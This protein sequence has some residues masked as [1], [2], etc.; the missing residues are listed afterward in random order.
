MTISIPDITEFANVADLFGDTNEFSLPQNPVSLA[1]SQDVNQ[2]FQPNGSAGVPDAATNPMLALQ[3]LLARRGV[4]QGAAN[5][6]PLIRLADP[7][8]NVLAALTEELSASVEEMMADAG[9]AKV[10]IRY[11]HWLED[12]MVSGVSIAQDL[13]LL[14]DPIPSSPVVG[15]VIQDWQIRWG[16]KVREISIQNHPD[17]T[18]TIEIQAVSHREHTKHLLFGASPWLPP[19][20]QLPK[21]YIIPGP[22]RSILFSTGFVNLARLFVPGLSALTNPL[23]PASWINPLNPDAALNVN[24]LSWPIQC[25]FVDPGLDSSQWSVLAATWT[26]WHSTMA[27]LLSN[28]GC[29]CRAYTWLTTDATSPHTELDALINT[30]GVVIEDILAALG[31]GGSDI[32]SLIETVGGDISNL[33]RP[34]RNCVVLSFEDKSGIVG[35]TGTAL[36]GLLSLVGVTLDDMITT[37]VFDQQS[38][39]VLNGENVINVDQITPFFETLVGVEQTLPQVIFRDGQF[40]GLRERS[41][42]MHKGSPM[43]IMTGGHSPA[44]VNQLQTFAIKYALAEISQLITFGGGQTLGGPATGNTQVPASDGLDALYQGQLNDVLLAWERYTDP[45]RALYGGEVQYQEYME[46]GSGT[47]YTV[48]GWLSLAEG[49]WKTRAFYGFEAK[50]NNG[51]PWIYGVDFQ[52]G[53]RVGFE[54]DGII[55][56]DQLTAVRYKYDRKSPRALEISVGDDRDR[57]DPIAGGL[58]IMQ[59]IYSLVSAI[60]G[61]GTLFSG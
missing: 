11:E 50:Y 58:R 36:D 34:T 16:G 21:M 27:D 52:L 10:V 25:A 47:A 53:D 19:E 7:N 35:P 54:M 29:I 60:A 37:V 48:A 55:Y 38:Q 31:L 22:L 3:Y 8:M 18:S 56:V 4:I 28:A 23:N 9:Q 13:H 24:P 32:E 46:R 49:H 51:Q 33:A 1:F 17:G 40:T 26:D 15:G 20:V 5:Q 44:I 39:Q 42:H 43:A 14:I 45:L 59:G 2:F 12:Y 61:E 30:A 41:V 57:H 6:Q